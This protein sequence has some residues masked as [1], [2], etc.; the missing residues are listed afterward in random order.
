[1]DGVRQGFNVFK[2]LTADPRFNTSIVLLENY[3]VQAVQ[4]V[5]PASTSLASEER[6][7]PILASPAIWFSGDDTQAKQE[8]KEYAARIR[9]GMYIGSSVKRHAYVNYAI[10]SE[11]LEEVYGYESWRLS[12]LKSLKKAWD[13]KNKFGW[14]NPIV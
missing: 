7:R 8:A 4:A 1:M 13:P 6:S 3:G 14:Y 11:S 2:A 10:G 9:D 12:K 5:D